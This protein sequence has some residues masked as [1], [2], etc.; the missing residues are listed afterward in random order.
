M[1]NGILAISNDFLLP[2]ESLK[3][4]PLMAPNGCANDAKLAAFRK[5]CIY[6]I[7][8]LIS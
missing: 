4:H 7:K 1:I 2:I 8:Y 6:S 5:N 3:I